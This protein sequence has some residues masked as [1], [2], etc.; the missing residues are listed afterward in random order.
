MRH[1]AHLLKGLIGD[2]HLDCGM[3]GCLELE[4]GG[5]WR[6]LTVRLRMRAGEDDLALIGTVMGSGMQVPLENREISNGNDGAE[7]E[8]YDGQ[9]S[10]GQNSRR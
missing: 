4:V 10:R 7:S 3:R 5:G 1:D 2:R 8:M 6:G 9:S